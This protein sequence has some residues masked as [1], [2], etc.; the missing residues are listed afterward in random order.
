MLRTAWAGT[1]TLA[2]VCVLALGAAPA[3]AGKKG[4]KGVP[5]LPAPETAPAPTPGNGFT[6]VPIAG[7][8]YYVSPAG[9][10]NNAGT[11]YRKPWR[12]VKRVNRA[13]LRPGDGVLFEGGATFSDEVLTPPASG[14]P[15][16]P[17]VLGSYGPAPATI[18]RGAWFSGRDHLVFQSL[19]LD[20]PGTSGLQGRGSGIVVQG[21]TAGRTTIGLWADGADWTI[22]DSRVHS[23]ADSGMVVL[24][25]RPTIR[26]NAV[27]DTGQDASIPY[28]RHGIYL[29]AAQA[30]VTGNAIS[31]FADSGVSVRNRDSVVEGN[32]ISG[33]PIGISWFQ[34]DAEAGTS[35]WVAN[36]ISDTT[37]AGIYVSAQDVG[38]PTRESFKI[39][40]NTIAPKA[41]EHLD[42][43][44][45]EG[46]YEVEDNELR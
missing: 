32:R 38:G 5:P 21:V 12:T 33:G 46:R 29:K 16:A 1:T 6:P 13:K 41:G 25:Q 9:N 35:R 26:D 24:G 8:V 37:A 18:S 15:G 39:S 22:E 31:S 40:R 20:A 27:V 43:R 4:G 10:D 42:L 36:E 7:T 34:E 44:P 30:S 14:A 28:G 2:A 11:S 45:T 3:Q 23:T 17:I 19:S